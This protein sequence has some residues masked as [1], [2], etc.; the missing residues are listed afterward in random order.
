MPKLIILTGAGLSAESGL[1]TFRDSNGL[2]EN[3]S[4][5]QVCHGDTWRRNFALVHRFYN[6]RRTQLGT[7]EPNRAH[8]MIARWQ[9]LYDTVL[10]TQNVDDLLE[11]AGCQDV[12]HL[13][14]FLPEL[15][16]VQCEYV[17]DIGYTKWNGEKCPDGGSI[18]EI[19]PHIIFF[20]ESAPRYATLWRTFNELKARDVVL[21]IGTSGVVLPINDM[22]ARYPGFKILNN[23]T[24]EPSIQ[25]DNFEK[26]L[27]MPATKAVEEID[28]ILS[29]KFNRGCGI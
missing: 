16:C 26:V 21:I 4:I 22:A 6:D 27:Y 12:V 20:G 1:R 14:G 19:R 8:L 18:S 17:W 7:V 9:S 25:D 15:R 29:E 5:E 11:R 3:H 24:P 23:L 28:A 10:L 2:W 13:H